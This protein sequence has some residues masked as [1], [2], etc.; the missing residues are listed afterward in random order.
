MTPT[1]LCREALLTAL[2]IGAPILIAGVVTGLLIG[3]LQAI[4]Q[5]ND[6]TV[7]FVPKV[8]VMAI[9]FMLCL[10]WFLQK[11]MDFTQMTF[12]NAANISG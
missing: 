5:I 1:D 10:P 7:S 12:A 2:I 6:Q 8:V 9:V 11:L 4:T 3:L